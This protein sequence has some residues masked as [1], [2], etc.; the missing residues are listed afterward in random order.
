MSEQDETHDETQENDDDDGFPTERETGGD[1]REWEWIGR[2]EE[3]GLP[4]EAET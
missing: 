4:T 1:D 2:V 3:Q